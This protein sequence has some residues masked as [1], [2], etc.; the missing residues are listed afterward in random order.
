MPAGGG[1][2]S[3]GEAKEVPDRLSPRT[4]PQPE[5]RTASGVGPCRAEEG[6]VRG[7]P[8]CEWPP[9][10]PRRP[11]TKRRDQHPPSEHEKVR[12]RGWQ[13]GLDAVSDREPRAPRA[14]KLPR[15][16]MRRWL[17]VSLWIVAVVVVLAAGGLGY[18]WWYFNTGN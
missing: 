7:A 3:R 6:G 15:M 12:R 4:A 9:F 13:R 17:K 2:F 14:R 18:M 5:L 11:L 10:F 1:F 16:P 8:A